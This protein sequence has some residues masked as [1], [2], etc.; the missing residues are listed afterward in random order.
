[1]KKNILNRYARTTDKKLII[2]IAAEKVESLYNDLDKYAPY[3][4]KEL[5]QDLVDYLID[6]ASEIGNEDFVI[7]FHLTTLADSKLTSRVKTSIHNYFL[8]LIDLEFRKLTKMARSSSIF[9]AIG[10]VILSLS[11]WINQEIAGHETV[12]ANVFAEGLNVAA[13][14]SLWHAIANMLINWTP[15][16][17]QIKMYHR[18]AKA[19]I[20]FHETEQNHH[21]TEPF[22]TP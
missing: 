20:L 16:R 4:K 13:W 14:V 3:R 21:G 9:F 10:I 15:H 11:V 22:T 17:Q 2:D 19:P 6:S 5:D 1:M 7:Q 18:V 12:I 8:Y